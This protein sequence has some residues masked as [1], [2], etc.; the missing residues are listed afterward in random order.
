MVGAAA[1]SRM[2]AHESGAEK[3]A[4]GVHRLDDG[5]ALNARPA[6]VAA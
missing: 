6:G 5:A 2:D 1:A 4:A 3:A